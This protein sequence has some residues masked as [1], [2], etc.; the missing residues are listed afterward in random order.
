MSEGHLNNWVRTSLLLGA[1]AAGTFVTQLV[2]TYQEAARTVT[3]PSKPASM[4]N[5]SG[6]APHGVSGV[7]VDE[8]HLTLVRTKS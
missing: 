3:Y 6:H 7:D 4:T 8:K 1:L 5:A 2:P